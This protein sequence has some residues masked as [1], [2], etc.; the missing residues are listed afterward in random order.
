MTEAQIRQ[1]VVDV[2]RGWVGSAYKS[3]GH[4]DI[5]NTYN[6]HKPLARGYALKMDDA[7]CAGTISAAWIKSDTVSVAVT[8]V[9][10]PKIVEL[11]KAKGIWVE[12]D[13]FIPGLGDAIAYDWDDTGKGDN[14]GSADH[15]GIVEK[16]ENGN[17]TVIEGNMGSGS[18]VGYVG[19]RKI[20]VNGRYIRGFI[21]PPYKK[22]ATNSKT[23]DELAREVIDGKWGN[24]S[25]RRQRLTAA[26]YN[27]EAVQRRVNEILAKPEPTPTPD[28]QYAEKFDQKIAGRYVVKPSDG[29]NL[30]YGPSSKY[31]IIKALPCGTIVQNYGYYSVNGSVKWYY[32]KVG[33]LVGFVCSRYLARK[34]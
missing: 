22:L 9:S 4:Y 6:S 26:G 27:Y 15:V 3:A 2:M 25:E 21:C 5:V 18:P 8:E 17:I 32:V 30:R 14:T 31:K 11:A 23:V 29:L 13:A 20:P 34:N 33:S 28:V 16:V 19:R 12:N 1:K 7:Y 24:G 10:A